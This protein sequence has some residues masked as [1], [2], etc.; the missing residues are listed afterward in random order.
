VS[1]KQKAQHPSGLE[2][3][4]GSLIESRKSTNRSKV[5]PL[6]F[7]KNTYVWVR[8]AAYNGDWMTIEYVLAGILLNS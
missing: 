5:K 7:Y 6:R 2:R 4:V 1:K 3:M 8:R